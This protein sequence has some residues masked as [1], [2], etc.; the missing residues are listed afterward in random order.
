LNSGRYYPILT[1]KQ[2]EL[3]ALKN[4]TEPVKVPM[5]PLLDVPPIAKKR[6]LRPGEPPPPPMSPEDYLHKRLLEPIESHWSDIRD[7][8]I[9]LDGFEQYRPGGAH[10]L[11]YLAARV[12]NYKGRRIVVVSNDSSPEYRAALAQTREAFAG[13]AVRIHV[14]PGSK[15]ASATD[16]INELRE[17]FDLNL[18]ETDLVLDFGAIAD[19][20]SIQIEFAAGH[21]AAIPDLAKWRTVVFAS[22]SAPRSDQV[23]SGQFKRFGRADWRLWLQVAAATDGVALAF[24]DYGVTGPRPQT[25]APQWA[26]SPNIRYTTADQVLYLKG[27]LD[28]EPADDDEVGPRYPHLCDRLVRLPEYAAGPDSWGDQQMWRAHRRERGPGGPGEWIQ[29]SSN[30]HL[31]HVVRD[32][33]DAD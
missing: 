20:G 17:A 8:L 22:T 28:G 4:L 18:F 3:I 14:R 32:L 31:A 11:E 27:R 5:T 2:G 30:H 15:P 25:D 1:A 12:G 10:P 24:A 16:A 33:S 7:I 19:H 21:L 6:P 13:V 9:D 26:P 23:K 29:F